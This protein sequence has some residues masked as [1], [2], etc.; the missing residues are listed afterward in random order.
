MLL[1]ACPLSSSIALTPALIVEHAASGETTTLDDILWT[2]SANTWNQ[3]LMIDLG[4]S[5]V[6]ARLRTR[7][8]T[9]QWVTSFKASY[10]VDLVDTDEDLFFTDPA[11]GV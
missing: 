10:G 9:D 1:P 3:R 5:K 8:A 6:V 11:T 4:E 2:S 7:G